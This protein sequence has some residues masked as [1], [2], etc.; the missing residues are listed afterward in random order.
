MHTPY[1]NISGNDNK[2][3][4][5]L[6]D[7]ANLDKDKWEILEEIRTMVLALGRETREKVIYGGLMF[8]DKSGQDWGGIFPYT[9]HLS[10][11]FTQGA[12]LR[13]PASVLEGKGKK[14]RHLKIRSA[15]DILDKNLA[16]FITEAISVV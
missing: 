7:M 8:S 5:F 13:D 10:F 16:F 1:T 12:K 4:A 6:E 9:H 11:E 15:A 2:V 14:R 3:K